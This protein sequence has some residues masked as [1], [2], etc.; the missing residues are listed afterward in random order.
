[1]GVGRKKM[2]VHPVCVVLI[3]VVL[4]ATKASEG[5]LNL[6]SIAFSSPSEMVFILHT[7]ILSQGFQAL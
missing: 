3:N 4:F 7:D 1:M 2:F 5:V 6:E